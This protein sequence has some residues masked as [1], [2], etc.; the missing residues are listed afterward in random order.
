MQKEGF[1]Y[2]E[3]T[4]KW[5]LFSF[6]LNVKCNIYYICLHL[7]VTSYHVIL[8]SKQWLYTRSW[9]LFERNL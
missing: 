6:D 1:E 2:C 8:K 7:Q 3:F 5:L 9:F 4:F